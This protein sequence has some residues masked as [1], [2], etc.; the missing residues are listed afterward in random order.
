M[1]G[2]PRGR[3]SFWWRV[4]SISFLLWP[5]AVGC[6]GAICRG[7]TWADNGGPDD[8]ETD[9]A[10]TSPLRPGGEGQGEMGPAASATPDQIHRGVDPHLTCPLR[11][12]GGEGRGGGHTWPANGRPDDLET[13]IA[14]TSPLRQAE[15]ARVRW[16]Q[17]GVPRRIK[18]IVALIPTSPVLSAP[19]AESNVAAARCVV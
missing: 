14:P 4:V 7:H 17:P 11:P 12:R 18:F 16:A 2:W 6:C 3:R 15:R 19:G 9:I 8:L 13:D 10:S 5:A 1:S